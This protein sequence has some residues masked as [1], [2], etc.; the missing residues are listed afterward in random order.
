MLDVAHISTVD[1]D[2]D[3]WSST[4][5]F[6]AT[7]NAANCDTQTIAIATDSE[8]EADET[9]SVTIIDADVGTIGSPNSAIVTITGGKYCLPFVELSEVTLFQ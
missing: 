1:A 9:F 2:F 3:S 4:I 5:T 6:T 8:T 7:G